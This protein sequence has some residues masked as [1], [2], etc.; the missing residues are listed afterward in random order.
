MKERERNFV[1]MRKKIKNFQQIVKLFLLELD[2]KKVF[3]NTYK[4]I[5][6][7]GKVHKYFETD[8]INNN[9]ST[10]NCV[11]NGTFCRFA[12][13]VYRSDAPRV[14]FSQIEGGRIPCVSAEDVAYILFKHTI[15]P[16]RSQRL[17]A[18]LQP[19]YFK[20]KPFEVTKTSAFGNLKVKC[21][22]LGFECSPR[23]AITGHKTQGM[24]LANLVVA[25][26]DGH[27]YGC[28]GWV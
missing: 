25:S 5:D 27:R 11:C 8:V 9:K 24:Y 22:L 7:E 1:Q 15:E 16:Y 14:F 28:D 12:K 10:L 2:R 6:V 21:K 13:V 20:L 4:W 18:N 23:F 26:F 3:S 19:G 17:Y